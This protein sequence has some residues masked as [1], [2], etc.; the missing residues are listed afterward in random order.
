[1]QASVSMYGALGRDVFA[2]KLLQ[3]LEESKV[4]VDDLLHCDDTPTGM[5]HIWVDAT[6]ENSI[7]IVPGANAQLTREYIDA[8]IPKIQEVPWL[9]MQLEV[10]LDAMDYL[11]R[12][13]PLNT[14]KVILD[15]APPQPVDQLFTERVWLITPNEHELQAITGL[16]TRTALEI[17]Q[18][19]RRLLNDTA[20][21]AVLCKAG[22]RGAYLDDGQHFRH[23]P[24]YTVR[25]VDSTAAG[26]AFNGM[27]A[28]ALSENKPLE[29]AILLANAVGALCVTKPGAQQSLPWRK[30]L[31]A[32]IESQHL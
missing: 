26:D 6:G 28:V 25:S 18:A 20:A 14:P 11:L 7:A 30:D 15:P 19:C 12:K 13:L 9:L 29:E 31:E 5:A 10:P 32:F 1:M 8:V 3:S 27:L 22:S 21:E 23:F 17:Q 16:P 4:R 2:P 24:G